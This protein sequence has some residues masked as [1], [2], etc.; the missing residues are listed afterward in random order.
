MYTGL[1][2][3]EALALQWEDIDFTNRQISV[4]KSVC[5]HNNQPHIKATKTKSGMRTVVLLDRVAEAL[6]KIQTSDKSI[7]IFSGTHTPLTNSQFQ[8]RWE[9]YNQETGLSITAHQ[10]RHTFATILFEAE[11]NVKDAQNMMGHSDISVTQNIYTHIRKERT[12]TSFTK[13]NSYI[14]DLAL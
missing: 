7:Y 14:N 5:H 1:R 13:L 11:I 3:G 6:Q 2:K 10:L 12:A 9:K 8:C 4:T